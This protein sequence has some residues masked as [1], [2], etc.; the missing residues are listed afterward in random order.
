MDTH[1]SNVLVPFGSLSDPNLHTLRY[2]N[3][4]L[5][6]AF[7]MCFYLPVWEGTVTPEASEVAEIEFFPLDAVPAP[8]HKP[9]LEVLR[10]FEL[11]RQTGNFQAN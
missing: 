10:L 8:T 5:T 7:A 4:D 9:T 1:C 2:P 11:Y 6:H 3:G